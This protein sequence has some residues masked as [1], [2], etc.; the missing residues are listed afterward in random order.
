MIDI[1]Q[2]GLDKKK[3]EYE[4]DVIVRKLMI[5]AGLCDDLGLEYGKTGFVIFFYKYF[6]HKGN[7]V[8]ELFAKELLNDLLTCIKIYEYD[9]RQF[10]IGI[11]LGINY[12][13]QNSFIEID[14]ET[15]RGFD[16]QIMEYQIY[17]NSIDNGSKGAAY[18]ILSRYKK[19]NSILTDQYVRKIAE[20]FQKNEFN[21]SNTI[22]INNQITYLLNGINAAPFDLITELLN[23]N[24]NAEINHL[25]ITN[26]LA[27]LGLNLMN[28]IEIETL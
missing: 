25:G 21:N 28:R 2:E 26:G 27:G 3:K 16:N 12:L 20:L 23:N 1:S 13:S 18:Y 5:H 11:A 9:Y 10:L 19:K 6:R 17:N 14:D 22:F 7:P 24:D 4:L 8:I 15:M